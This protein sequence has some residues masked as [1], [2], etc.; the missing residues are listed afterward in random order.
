MVTLFT[1]IP[2]EG[3]S[4]HPAYSD[5]AYSDAVKWFEA[6]AKEDGL[7]TKIVDNFGPDASDEDLARSE[8]IL[9]SPDT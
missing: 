1:R 9:M 8:R 6:Q 2:R 4:W 3:H 7:E 5:D